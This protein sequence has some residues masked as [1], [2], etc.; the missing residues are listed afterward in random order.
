M[1]KKVLQRS[2]LIVTAGK[3]IGE[4]L[5]RKFGEQHH[6]KIQVMYNGWDKKDFNRLK[7][8]SSSSGKYIISYLGSL[9]GKQT[10]AYFIQALK[11]LRARG[12]L[13][14][15]LEIRFIGNFDFFKYL[16]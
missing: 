14:A 11:K 5:V 2:Q 7:K 13:P 3:L 4:D 12:D 16:V 1:G 9:Y 8:K 10:V 15:D 6:K